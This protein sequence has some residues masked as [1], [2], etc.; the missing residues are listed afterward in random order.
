MTH[1]EDSSIF[2]RQQLQAFPTRS[3]ATGFRSNRIVSDVLCHCSKIVAI[4]SLIRFNCQHA[5][6]I[7]LTPVI[8]HQM[9]Y[10]SGVLQIS[11]TTMI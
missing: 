2:Q 11:I 9:Q 5:V 8:E 6:S 3:V 4:L 7:Q 10:C 1:R